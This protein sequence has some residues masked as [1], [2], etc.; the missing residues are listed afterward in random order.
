LEREVVLERQRDGI[1]AAK[2]KG[3]YKGRKPAARAKSHEI[4]I[5]AAEGKS[6]ETDHTVA[7]HQPSV[8]LSH[9]RG[10]EQPVV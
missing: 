10:S 4:R 8:S 2:A 3:L 9:T 6:K 1:A 7:R 5:V